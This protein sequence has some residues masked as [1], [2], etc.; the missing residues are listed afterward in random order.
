M[1]ADSESMFLI[2]RDSDDD[3]VSITSTVHS[4]TQETYAVERILYEEVQYDEEEERD[5]V[6][7]LGTRNSCPTMAKELVNTM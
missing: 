1:A 3:T 7:Y 4:D 2:N 6:K 5:V